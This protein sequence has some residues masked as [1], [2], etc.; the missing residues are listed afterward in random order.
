MI[1]IGDGV[2]EPKEASHMPGVKKMHQQSKNSSKAKYIFGHL[3]GAVGV[4]IGTSDKWFCLPLFLQLQD[5]VKTIF[6]WTS[7]TE[8]QDS[9]VV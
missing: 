6:G 7:E 8:R 4:L 3:F 9:H 2:K 5:G 1:L